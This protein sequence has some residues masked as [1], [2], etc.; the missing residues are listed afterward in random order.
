[1]I[2]EWDSKKA[3]HNLRKHGIGF[4][5]ARTVFNDPL[6]R[7]FVDEAHSLDERREI[8]VG[9]SVEGD[10]LLVCFSERVKDV[11]RIY[12]ARRA[13]PWERTDYEEHAAT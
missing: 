4:E 6:A 8:I 5:E 2:F 3:A 1:M 7:I 12:S 13:T 10:L 11:V 9:H